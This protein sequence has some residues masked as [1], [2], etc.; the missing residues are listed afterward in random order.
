[1]FV[2]SYDDLLTLI[3]FLFQV[4]TQDEDRGFQPCVV[5]RPA[6]DEANS[7]NPVVDNKVAG[8]GVVLA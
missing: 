2:F 6:E 1:L 8:A 7:I 4:A 5:V 3:R